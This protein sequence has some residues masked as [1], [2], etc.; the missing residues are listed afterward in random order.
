[1]TKKDIEKYFSKTDKKLNK[2]NLKKFMHD[3][4]KASKKA[5]IISK[6]GNIITAINKK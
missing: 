5:L 6:D 4:E 3:I 1:M 2:E